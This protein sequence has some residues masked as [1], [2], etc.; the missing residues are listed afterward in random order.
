[1][2]DMFQL[3]EQPQEAEPVAT[4]NSGLGGPGLNC[5]RGLSGPEELRDDMQELLALPDGI[6]ECFWEILQPCLVGD[7]SDEQQQEIFALCEAHQLDPQRL[8]N[9]LRAVRFLVTAAARTALTQE[10]VVQDVEQ[11]VKDG[12]LRLALA[13]LLPCFEQAL[14]LLRAQIVARTITEHGKLAEGVHWRV[15]KII[16]SEHGDGVNLPVAVLTFSY[17]EGNRQER[18]TLHLLP[19]QLAKLKAACLEMLP[20]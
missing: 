9:P 3:D 12:Q 7:P 14:P 15:D 18:I 5:V 6:R 8:Q 4:A 11:L 10:A 20:D 13:V 2:A 1:M 17:R 16:N 19:D